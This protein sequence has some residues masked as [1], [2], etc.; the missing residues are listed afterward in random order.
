[1]RREFN[2]RLVRAVA[3][4]E[5]EVRAED[6]LALASPLDDILWLHPERAPGHD[7][8]CIDCDWGHPD[9]IKR[10]ARE[11]IDTYLKGDRHD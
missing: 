10:D 7:D 5:A 9:N 11:E 6:A 3:Q 2:R 8:C 1:M 4:A